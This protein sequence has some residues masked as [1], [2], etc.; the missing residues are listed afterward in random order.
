MAENKDGS[1][2]LTGRVVWFDPS[3]GIGFLERD[4]GQGDMFVHWSNI[5]M[6][7]FKTLKPGQSVEFEVGENHKGP[8]AVNVIITAEPEQEE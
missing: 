6:E 4:D 1:V 2:K 8:Q 5:S 3:R 7:G